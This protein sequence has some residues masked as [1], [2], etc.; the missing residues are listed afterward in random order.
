M[1]TNYKENGINYL[2]I[3]TAPH[4]YELI[5]IEYFFSKKN[6]S[7]LKE[8]WSQENG[9]HI[10]TIKIKNSYDELIAPLIY[11][12]ILNFNYMKRIDESTFF[13]Y[14]VIWEEYS[15]DELKKE[16]DL[17]VD[18]VDKIINKRGEELKKQEDILKYLYNKKKITNK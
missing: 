14:K 2:E 5:L 8:E 1:I 11:F 6:I 9:S 3:T 4:K 16:L 13:K 18:D 17:F 10:M 12:K 15:N 7:I